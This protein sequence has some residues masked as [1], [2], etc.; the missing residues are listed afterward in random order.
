MGEWRK[1]QSKHARRNVWGETRGQSDE[2]WQDFA[3]RIKPY[4]ELS[5]LRFEKIGTE[6]HCWQQIPDTKRT[7]DMYW[8]SILRFVDD[9]WGY[10]TV[11]YRNDEGRWRPTDIKKLPLG[12]AVPLAA[13]FYRQKMMEI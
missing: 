12:R 7:G 11:M 13:E 4:K 8:A 3:L 2:T 1:D 6:I 10:W 5:Q 9:G